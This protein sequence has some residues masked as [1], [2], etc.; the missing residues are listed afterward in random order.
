MGDEEPRKNQKTKATDKVYPPQ[1][2][3]EDMS[4]EW[5]VEFLYIPK[6]HFLIELNFTEGRKMPLKLQG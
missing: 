3:A 1:I 5:Q 2:F 6:Y 4:E